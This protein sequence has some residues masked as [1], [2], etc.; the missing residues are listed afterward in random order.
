MEKPLWLI[1]SIALLA[2]TP[3]CGSKPIPLV[4]VAGTTMTIAIPNGLKI[5]YGLRLNQTLNPASASIGAG[6]AYDPN[7]P[8]EDPQRG[9]L[10]FTLYNSAGTSFVSHLPIAF[11]TRVNA[12]TESPL[13]INA[14]Q[15]VDSGQNLAF[16]N[17]PKEVAGGNYLIKVRRYRRAAT[18]P[19]AYAAEPVQTTTRPKLPNPPGGFEDYLGWGDDSVASG[20]P[21]SSAGIPITILSNPDTPTANYFTPL[22]GWADI[23]PPSHVTWGDVSDDVPAL[24]PVPAFEIQV[25]ATTTDERPAAWEMRLAYPRNRVVVVGV[26]PLRTGGSGAMVRWSADETAVVSCSDVGTAFLD[27]HVI[28]PDLVTY[29]VRVA[30]TLRNFNQTCGGRATSTTFGEWPNTFQAFN[31][32]GEDITSETSYVIPTQSF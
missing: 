9:E 14:G 32:E 12:S 11:I 19:Y 18:S 28:D 10:I 25:P 15:L 22:R 2:A 5:G 17:I 21:T 20:L 3:G 8:Y 1:A 24:V 29:G 30:Y 16:L 26:E 23:G 13:A 31:A 7:S 6:P 27:V 4:A